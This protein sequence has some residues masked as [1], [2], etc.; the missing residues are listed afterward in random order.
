VSIAIRPER[1]RLHTEANGQ[2]FAIP[3]KVVEHIYVGSIIK[4]VVSLPGGNKV[5][6][7]ETPEVAHSFAVG[8][9]VFVN[10]EPDKAVVI[11]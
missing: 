11:T 8:Q 6:V 10:W 9:D 5:T 7:N 4:T 1:L 2:S 3:G